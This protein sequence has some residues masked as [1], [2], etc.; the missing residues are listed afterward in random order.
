MVS[1]INRIANVPASVP[2][3]LQDDSHVPYCNADKLPDFSDKDIETGDPVY[4]CPHLIQ[5]ELGEIYEIVL[6]D[7]KCM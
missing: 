1:M 5:L 3:L 4:Y 6:L 7:S 2:G